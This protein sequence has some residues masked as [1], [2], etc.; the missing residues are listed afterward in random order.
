MYNYNIIL[1]YINKF[2]VLNQSSF[3]SCFFFNQNY[4]ISINIINM[5]I[6]I[7]ALCFMQKNLIFNILCLELMLFSVV[8]NFL[9]FSISLVD[10]LGQVM[11]MCLLALISAESVIG[12]SLIIIL[13]F[14]KGNIEFKSLINLK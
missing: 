2:N 5:F 3:P 8:L 4:Y 10:P 13:F 1:I 9:I 6:S 7:F 12:L 14:L 11:A